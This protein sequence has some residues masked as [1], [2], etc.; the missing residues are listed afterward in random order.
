MID[1]G[2]GRRVRIL[3]RFARYI[4]EFELFDPLDGDKRLLGAGELPCN[5]NDD[6]SNCKANGQQSPQRR[7][8]STSPM[9]ILPFH[10]GYG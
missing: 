2:D 8:K 10:Q 1:D 9:A 6:I 3:V 4:A 7:C 5:P